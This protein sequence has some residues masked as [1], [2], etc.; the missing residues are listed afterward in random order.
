VDLFR[1]ISLEQTQ[2]VLSGYQQFRSQSGSTIH[3]QTPFMNQQWQVN[4]EETT[5]L[6]QSAQV[7][8]SGKKLL[9]HYQKY[10]GAFLSM[11]S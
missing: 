2:S 9:E 11:K 7:H 10:F 1:N 4:P 3:S 6:C 8:L 5:R